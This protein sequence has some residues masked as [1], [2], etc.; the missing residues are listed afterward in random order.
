[1]IVYSIEFAHRGSREKE[2]RMKHVL[3]ATLG[4]SPVVVSSMFDLLTRREHLSVD[5]VIVLHSSGDKRAGGYGMIDD[6]LKEECGVD[7]HELPFEDAYTEEDFFT[8]RQE[9]FNRLQKHQE[10]NH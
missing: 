3:I 1:M 4:D 7:T 9:L 6:A 10:C 2:H 5:E 8:F